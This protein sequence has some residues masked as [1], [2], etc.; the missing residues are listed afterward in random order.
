M[1]ALERFTREYNFKA[2]P[3]LLYTLISTP[4]GL[5]R[6]FADNVF[7]EDDLFHFKWE[8]SDQMARL[9]D[10]KENEWVRFQWLEDFHKDCILEMRILSEPVSSELALVVTD[11]AEA[12]DLEF[13]HRLWDTQVKQLQR[14]FN[15]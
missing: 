1:A 13:Y 14:L 5:S 12:D 6:W 7:V 4:E 9:V 8:G 2:T 3:K 15:V 10:A 11:Y